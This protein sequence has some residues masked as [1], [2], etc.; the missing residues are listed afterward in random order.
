MERIKFLLFK[1]ALKVT[2]WFSPEDWIKKNIKNSLICLE[3]QREMDACN[4]PRTETHE[5]RTSERSNRRY[6][7]DLD[8]RNEY[9]NTSKVTVK[10]H[11]DEVKV[12]LPSQN[13]QNP[14]PLLRARNRSGPYL[15]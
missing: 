4:R 8:E 13:P 6:Y 9:T 2:L 7:T 14:K 5:W 12:D 1:T 15:L 11:A 10:T 3:R